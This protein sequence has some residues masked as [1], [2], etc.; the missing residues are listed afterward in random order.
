[1]VG[2]ATPAARDALMLLYQWIRNANTASS[3]ERKIRN[4]AGVVI[5]K[6]T[7]GDAGGVYDQ[8]KLVSG[9]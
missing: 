3:T 6:A 2:A 5:A 1:M 7:A 4:D 8:G 9:P